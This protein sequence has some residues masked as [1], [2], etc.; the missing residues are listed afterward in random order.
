MSF[1][2]CEMKWWN[3]KIFGYLWNP[4]SS[5]W[6]FPNFIWE[7]HTWPTEPAYR[8]I[9]VQKKLLPL[10]VLE[11]NTMNITS[12]CFDSQW[13]P[14]NFSDSFYVFNHWMKIICTSCSTDF[15]N[16]LSLITVLLYTC[17]RSLKKVCILNKKFCICIYCEAE[18]LNM[19]KMK[20]IVVYF[21]D[22]NLT[23]CTTLC[24]KNV[25]KTFF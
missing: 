14:L 23:G 19:I 12:C 10:I 3:W 5:D 9:A 20:R 17:I 6:K 25:F 16:C 18:V 24:F 22:A 8:C 15:K 4:A 13:R 7:S 1:E 11:M 2:E 21:I